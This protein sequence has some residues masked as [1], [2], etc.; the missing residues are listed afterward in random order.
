ML[1]EENISKSNKIDMGLVTKNKKIA[2]NFMKAHQ[3]LIMT[4]SLPAD[5]ASESG[6]LDTNVL[7][8][9]NAGE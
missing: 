4:E 8:K 9:D 6:V 1:G 2:C 3:N 5:M 7:L